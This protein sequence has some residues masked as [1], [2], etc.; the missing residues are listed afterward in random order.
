MKE[1]TKPRIL[2]VY[3]PKVDT[4]P[5]YKYLGGGGFLAFVYSVADNNIPA[6]ILGTTLWGALYGI[7]KLRHD[8]AYRE[9]KLD[10][11][12]NGRYTRL[13]EQLVGLERKIEDSNK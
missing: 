7:E 11:M 13:D 3:L 12:Q 5:V 1:K 8:T 4:E 10:F 2:D 9:A 6:A